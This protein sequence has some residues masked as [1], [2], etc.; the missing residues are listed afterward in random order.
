MP[1]KLNVIRITPLISPP[2]PA[3]S[4]SNNNSSESEMNE[5]QEEEEEEE[6]EEKIVTPP[7]LPS[8]KNPQRLLQRKRE[9]H[10]VN[11][12]CIYKFVRGKQVGKLCGSDLTDKDILVH[13]GDRFCSTCR[14]KDIVKKLLEEEIA[15]QCGNCLNPV[16]KIHSNDKYCK[17]CLCNSDFQGMLQANI[18]PQEETA[19]QTEMQSTEKL[20]PQKT[21]PHE[22]SSQ[23]KIEEFFTYDDIVRLHTSLGKPKTMQTTKLKG[24]LTNHERFLIE[25]FLSLDPFELGKVL[26]WAITERTGA[27]K[28]WA[29]MSKAVLKGKLILL[30]KELVAESMA[31]LREKRPLFGHL[32]KQAEKLVTELAPTACDLPKEAIQLV[33]MQLDQAEERENPLSRF[34]FDRI[35]V[36][37]KETDSLNSSDLFNAYL[38][39]V[40]STDSMTNNKYESVIGFGRAIKKHVLLSKG[41]NGKPLWKISKYQSKARHVGIKF[42]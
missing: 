36:T 6:E 27:E 22:I 14:S 34:I 32:A 12:T 21:Q 10:G 20:P 13:G 30:K 19:E 17:S 31:L 11:G 9:V 18:S 28:N 16:L 8:L 35:R 29:T 38:D 42:V 39:W 1:P 40:D 37:Q 23:T 7:P 15:H 24:V 33:R 25:V 2:L 5:T 3:E 41:A 4:N 26:V